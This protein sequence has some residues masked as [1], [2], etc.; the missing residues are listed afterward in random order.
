M[1]NSVL[2]NRNILHSTKL[3]IYKSTVKSI[4]TY[5][6]ETWSIKRKHTQQLL[7]T[8]MD[9]LRGSAR[10]SR[11]DRIRDETIRTKM[12][13]KKDILREMEEQQLRWYGHITRMENCRIARQIA[14]W[15][16]QGDGGA[17]DQST[18]GRVG[19]GTA[20]KGETLRMEN[21]SVESSG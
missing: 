11:M 17:A 5:G 1:L 15:N 18:H 10:I 2:W 8:E 3:L 13:L 19:L 16:P 20:R 9:Y 6:D 14:E 4:L 7:A 21:V 12:G